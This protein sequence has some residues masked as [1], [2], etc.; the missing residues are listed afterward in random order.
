MNKDAK[1]VLNIVV[2]VAAS[3]LTAGLSAY[4][5][6]GRSKTGPLLVPKSVEARIDHVVAWLDHKVGKKW[7]NK[8]LDVVQ[9]LLLSNLPPPLAALAGVVYTA[10][11]KGRKKGWS[12][13]QK[14]D[15]A[16]SHT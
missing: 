6:R 1:R 14:R 13:E 8:G 5:A 11:A 10:E 3:I 2:G 9:S 4:L 15:F 7:V 16:I 12:G